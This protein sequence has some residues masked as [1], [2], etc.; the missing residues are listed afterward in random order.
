MV[1]K[2]IYVRKLEEKDGYTAWLVNGALVRKELDE[3][4]TEYDHHSRFHFIPEKE[5][6]IDDE[7]S[8]KEYALYIRRLLKEV[9]FIRNGMSP[10]DAAQQADTFEEQERQ[11]GARIKKILNSQNQDVIRE[12]I[13]K[14]KIT[15]Y[16]DAVALWLV[17]GDLVRSTYSVEYSEGGHDIVYSWIPK[18]EIWIEES[19]KPEERDFIILHELHERYLM[20]S[21]KMTYADAHHG[22]TIVEDHYRER[23]EGL[24]E[25]IREEMKNNGSLSHDH[26]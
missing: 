20:A 14:K 2:N 17:D 16:G 18:N 7:M 1:P 3:N 26:S 13:R 22:A 23:R 5:F 8:P 11:K 12:K 9:E 15:E 21:K 19:L 10:R 25:R 24:L 4:F 6:W